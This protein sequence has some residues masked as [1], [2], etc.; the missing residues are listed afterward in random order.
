MCTRGWQRRITKQRREAGSRS[1]LI[2]TTLLCIPIGPRPCRTD[3]SS[4]ASPSLAV[5][6]VTACWNGDLPSA[7]AAVA[8][9]ASVNEKGRAPFWVDTVPPLR[10][11][12]F[13]QRH[14]VVVWLLSLGAD[15]NGDN[16]MSCGT[17]I[18]TAGILQLLIDA[19]GDINLDGGGVLPLFWAVEGNNFQDKVRV[20]L[21]QP[22]LCFTV[23]CYGKTPERYARDRGK[24][25][26]AD[27]IAQ[28]VGFPFCWGQDCAACADGV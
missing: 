27:M 14:D 22:S 2:A 19:G 28:E 24:P 23:E 3:M 18:S 11:A 1:N 9:G 17:A 5:R 21:A 13:R 10:A 7:E 4:S 26:V 20:L 12:V 25:A 8:D 6:L 16:V 15:P